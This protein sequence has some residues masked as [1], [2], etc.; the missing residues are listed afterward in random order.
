MVYWLRALL[1]NASPRDANVRTG[2]S[3]FGP[4]DLDMAEWNVQRCSE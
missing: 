1:L 3:R 2:P 4:S